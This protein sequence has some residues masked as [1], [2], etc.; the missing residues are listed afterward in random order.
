[1]H[2]RLKP[3][4]PCTAVRRRSASARSLASRAARSFWSCSMRCLQQ[5]QQAAQ[6]AATRSH[7]AVVRSRG[8]QEKG[9]EAHGTKPA[10]RVLLTPTRH[11]PPPHT[12]THHTPT[13]THTHLC[14]RSACRRFF[15]SALGSYVMPTDHAFVRSRARLRSET[16]QRAAQRS[17]AAAA[18]LS[19]AAAAQHTAATQPAP[20]PPR[21]RRPPPQ[22]TTLTALLVRV[23]AV[24]HHDAAEVGLLNLLPA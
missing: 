13:H 18:H 4:W 21:Q 15:C 12:H 24:E 5:R 10:G 19:A 2:A 17:T 16:A 23:F 1:M 7:G 8:A 22:T 3:S 14:S 20:A 6:R 9:R 11:T